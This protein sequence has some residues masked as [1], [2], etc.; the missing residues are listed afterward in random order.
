MKYNL[1]SIFSMILITLLAGAIVTFIIG[2]CILLTAELFGPSNLVIDGHATGTVSDVF[3]KY[4][5]DIIITLVKDDGNIETFCTVN[6]ELY[7]RAIES[8]GRT[9]VDV[10]YAS[11]LVSPEM[12]TLLAPGDFHG[13]K[14]S[15]IT[16]RA[17]NIELISPFFWRSLKL[18]IG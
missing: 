17:L 8:L 18:L 7:S 10:T 14:G 9:R 12:L 3:R 16:G 11:V 5:G 13:C 1:K 15:Y 4:D 6:P 2:V